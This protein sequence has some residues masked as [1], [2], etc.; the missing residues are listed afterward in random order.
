MADKSHTAHVYSDVGYLIDG[1][2]QEEE[3]E[4][5][6]WERCRARIEHEDKLVNNRA[7]LFLVFNGM[8]AVVVDHLSLNNADLLM[9]IIIICANILWVIGSTQSVLITQALTKVHMEEAHDPVDRVARQAVLGW[10]QWIKATYIVG[11]Y[12]PLVLTAG[13][14]IAIFL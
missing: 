3:V 2:H 10:P 14:L 13:W 12:L 6:D 9:A 1:T 11:V 5:V 7:N 8:G 4:I